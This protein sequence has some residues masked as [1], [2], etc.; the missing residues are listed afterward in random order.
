VPYK[1]L[2][3]TSIITLVVLAIGL[4]GLEL[5][6]RYTAPRIVESDT[7]TLGPFAQGNPDLLIRHT[8]RGRR[9]IPNADVVIKNHNLSGRDIRMKINSLGFREDEM[10]ED[11]QDNEVRILILGDSITWGD[12]LQAEETYVEQ[13]ER[14]LGES[15]PTH[16]IEAINA[17]IGDI[18]IEEEIDVLLETGLS[19]LPD[20]VIV[21]FYLNDSRPPWGFPGELGHRGFIRRHSVLAETVYRNFKLRQWVKDQ[22]ED[23]FV[24]TRRVNRFDW[25]DDRQGFLKLVTL[26]RYDWGAAWVPES[27]EIVDDRLEVLKALSREHDFKVAVVAFPVAFQVYAS[28]VEAYPQERLRGIAGKHDFGFVD[29]LPVLREHSNERLFF[30]QC[31]PRIRANAIIAEAIAYYLRAELIETVS[32]WR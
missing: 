25:Q 16:T 4:L 19:V 3:F 14:I 21:S 32:G 18:G 6:L 20:I 13:L 28:F 24:W 15:Y 10:P 9:L 27:W 17:G 30:D 26:A 29:L 2:L 31:H 7:S 8:P 22:G 1:R 23:R 12:Y 5:Y 11:K